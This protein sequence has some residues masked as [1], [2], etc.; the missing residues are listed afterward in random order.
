MTE[1]A[2][3]QSERE[4]MAAGA[5]YCCVDPELDQLR[6][7][8]RKAVHQHNSMLPDARGSMAP[9]LRALFAGVAEDAFVEAPFHCAYGMNITLGARVY[10]NAGCTILD[11][12]PVVI[13]SD[14][15]LGPGVQIYC[16]EHHKDPALRR[17][18]L[19]IARPVTIG[20]N[21]WIGGG[22]IILAGVTIGD[23]AIVGA[24]A[25]VTR[26]VPA[27]ATVVENPARVL[28]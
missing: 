12:A 20:E 14:T 2:V 15:M 28:R 17:K 4:K 22:A 21:V 5:W 3:T 19:E 6:N 9:A 8:A 23:G 16:A 1:M 13:G 27:G 24:G 11:T 26:D 7:H 18:G 25:V 10:L